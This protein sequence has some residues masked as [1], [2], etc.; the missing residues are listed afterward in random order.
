MLLKLHKSLS[1]K[2]WNKNSTQTDRKKLFSIVNEN[3]I[4]FIHYNSIYI[5]NID[6]MPN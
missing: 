2:Q 4:V 3:K 6:L 1:R 5:T